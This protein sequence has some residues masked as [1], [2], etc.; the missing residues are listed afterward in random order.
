MTQTDESGESRKQDRGGQGVDEARFGARR[1]G[2]VALLWPGR[3]QREWCCES[4]RLAADHAST[5]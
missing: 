1:S 2:L 3:K 5:W 4:C